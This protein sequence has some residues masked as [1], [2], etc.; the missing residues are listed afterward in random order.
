MSSSN[1]PD[2]Y[3][4]EYLICGCHIRKYVTNFT[5]FMIMLQCL[6]IFTGGAIPAVIS[7]IILGHVIYADKAEEPGAYMPYLVIGGLK[8]VA[9]TVCM[10][11]VI[12][13]MITKDDEM[14]L[15]LGATYLII[16]SVIL[17]LYI[18]YWCLVYRARQYM[19]R[20]SSATN[21]TIF[22]ILIEL[23]FLFPAEEY[24]GKNSVNIDFYN[25]SMNMVLIVTEVLVV[26][27]DKATKPWAYLPFLT[28]IAIFIIL[29][30][31]GIT[32][33]IAMGENHDAVSPEYITLAVFIIITLVFV[34]I[35]HWILVY[36][37]WRYMS[38]EVI[39]GKKEK[40]TEEGLQSSEIRNLITDFP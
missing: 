25:S 28:V 23:I 13:L 32:T 16:L 4:E 14:P 38:Q 21:L 8:I 5:I 27:A 18:F 34:S 7:L 35:Y 6:F 36:R 3:K 29:Y 39:S 26:F 22:M 1:F 40:T 24:M 11:V 31:L 15:D 30:T 20:E 37:A 2:V 10:V 12:V 33:I 19:I 17:V 9:M